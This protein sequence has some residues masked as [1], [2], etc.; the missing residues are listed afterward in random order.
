MTES[1]QADD[2]RLS[3]KQKLQQNFW[4]WLITELND[5]E[6]EYGT[7]DQAILQEYIDLTSIEQRRDSVGDDL[8]EMDRRETTISQ[9]LVER[10][11]E[12]DFRDA[13]Q[14]LLNFSQERERQG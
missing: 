11:T 6:Y 9:S 8:I 4:K 10:S 14:V 2:E 13:N 7:L 3:T 5:K 1:E 12:F